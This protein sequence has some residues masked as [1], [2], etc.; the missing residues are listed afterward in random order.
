MKE[1]KSKNNSGNTTSESIS[2]LSLNVCVEEKPG[3]PPSREFGAAHGNTLYASPVKCY[4]YIW[5]G[6]RC[7]QKTWK[8]FTGQL[9]RAQEQTSVC[10]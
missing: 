3:E 4:I 8:V 2:D 7:R 9:Y 1:V 5:R 10:S 6:G